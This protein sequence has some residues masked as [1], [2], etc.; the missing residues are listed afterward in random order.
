[1][2]WTEAAVFKTLDRFFP[3]G[4]F[5]L[6]PS[7]RNGTGYSRRKTRTADAIAVSVYPSRGLYF[8]GV[9]IKVSRSD[10]LRELKDAAKSESI[11]RFCKYWWIA[12]PEGVV[13]PGE[14][15]ETWGHIVVGEKK[16]TIAIPAPALDPAPPDMLFV[17]S[18]MRAVAEQS[19]TRASLVER[20][21]EIHDAAVKVGKQQA[22]YRLMELDAML[23]AFC[24]ASGLDLAGIRSWDAGN[25][26]SAVRVLVDTG[27]DQVEHQL[28]GWNR[29]M[30]SWAE[31][32]AR[33]VAEIETT[34]RGSH[35]STESTS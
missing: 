32:M 13:E 4:P 30:A 24:E 16:N 12:T 3:A 1:M 18:V 19:V 33:A 25:V 6:L 34:K 22:S 5:V 35:P 21:K 17:C 31:R 2:H 14:M 7:V 10:W 11:Q 23:E 20:E 29:E 15:P 28:R 9:E 27:V 8:A 26:G